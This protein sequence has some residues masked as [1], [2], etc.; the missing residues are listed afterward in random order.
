[1]DEATVANEVKIED[2]GPAKKR[3]TITIPAETISEKIDDSIATLAA[4]SALP[5]FRKGRAP[6]Q[7]I[8]RRFGTAVRNETKSQLIADAYSKAIEE[9]E[10][11]PVGEPEPTQPVD[12]LE[13][14]A[15]K[16]LTFS[17]D[18][19][20]VPEF[21]LPELE[22]IKVKKPMLEIGDEHIDAELKRQQLQLGEGK[23][24]ES[25][26]EPG[27][28]FRG[29]AVVSI[30]GEDEPFF[31][32]D[33]VPIIVPDPKKDDG[34]GQV[35]G[36]LVD[37]LSKKLKSAKVGDTITIET[38]GPEHHEREDIRGKD[39]VIE[40]EIREG[41]HVIPAT[42][43]QVLEYYGL[44]SEDILR[45]QIK[46]A[47]EQRRDEEQAA[48]MRE[49]IADY[50]VENIDF[51]L[52]EQLSA[53]QAQRMLERYRVEMLYKG[54]SVEEVEEQ[55]AE[56]RS[57][58]EVRARERLKLMFVMHKLA[59]KFEISVNDQEINGRIA[60]IAAQ[61]G[62][63]PEQLRAEFAQSGQLNQVAS[64]IR[65]H[66]TA[67]RII[68]NAEVTEVSA[69]EWRNLV[70]GK[71]AEAVKKKTKKKTTTK[72]KSTKKAGADAKGESKSKKSKSE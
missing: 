18:V 33:E 63:R 40:Y 43:E 29:Y 64:Q 69:D 47:L 32:K 6:K 42:V 51:P 44:T 15:G 50:L 28:Q 71:R 20:V 30:K 65:E 3:L 24:Q 57:E 41:L 36:L 9:H 49:Q 22:G 35:L 26:L 2:A 52:P 10:I 45:E 53:N 72:K 13:L 19:E 11:R 37:G 54:M 23:K 7:L 14:E 5:G 31:R 17:L 55:L 48:A 46:L 27:D 12:D 1:M 60:A 4:E 25:D 61:R 34:R 21:E 58:S 8:E 59:E 66:K 16:P 70:E 38:K 62:V 67:D 39:L 68:Q 56:M